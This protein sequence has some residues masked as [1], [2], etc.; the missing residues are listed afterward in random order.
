MFIVH[1]GNPL[2]IDI[3]KRCSGDGAEI[4]LREL[5]GVLLA[6]T[7]PCPSLKGR[8]EN[9][10]FGTH[11]WTSRKGGRTRGLAP[12]PAS[13]SK[14]GERIAHR[15]EVYSAFT[16]SPRRAFSMRALVLAMP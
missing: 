6:G 1:G 15:A 14:G 8:G 12:T 13:P 11:T 2:L 3:V 4:I 7:H 16:S 10:R 5:G 9:A